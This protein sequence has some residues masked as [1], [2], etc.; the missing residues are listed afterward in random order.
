VL[1]EAAKKFKEIRVSTSKHLSEMAFRV[2]NREEF[3]S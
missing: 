3:V 1:N 2:E